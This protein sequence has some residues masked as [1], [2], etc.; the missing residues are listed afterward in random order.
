MNPLSVT[1]LLEQITLTVHPSKLELGPIREGSF[2]VHKGLRSWRPEDLTRLEM[3]ATPAGFGARW[4]DYDTAGEAKDARDRALKAVTARK[5]PE[6]AFRALT[7]F[8]EAE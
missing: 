6:E 8:F 7:S 4:I 5:T 1:E 3:P 2:R